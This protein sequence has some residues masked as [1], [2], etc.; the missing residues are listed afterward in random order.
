MAGD[1]DES[2]IR[3]HAPK[4]QIDFVVASAMSWEQGSFLLAENVLE[5]VEFF[6]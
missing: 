2:G 1:G 3:T 4:D 6:G 5:L